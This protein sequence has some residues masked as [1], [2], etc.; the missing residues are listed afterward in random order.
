[1]L[2]RGGALL[3]LLAPLQIFSQ[4]NPYEDSE[5]ANPFFGNPF[6][7]EER[8]RREAE[9]TKQATGG[10]GGREVPRHFASRLY[11]EIF[12]TELPGVNFDEALDFRFSPKFSDLF[13]DDYIRWPVG[14]RYNFNTHLEGHFDLGLY[15]GNPFGSGD[16]AGAYSIEPGFKYT[17]RRIF[18]SD[19]NMAFGLRTRLPLADPPI[20]ISDGYA[21][22]QPY[23]SFSRRLRKDPAL[24]GYLNLRYEVVA[25]TPFTAH[26]EIPQPRDRISVS[27]GLIYYPGGRFRY[28]LEL[29]Y[30][31]NAWSLSETEKAPEGL[32]PPL[33]P[34]EIR[35]FRS[36]HELIAYPSI[37]WFPT[38][39]TRHGMW[40]PGNYDI[41]LRFEVPLVEKT[42]E[43]FAVSVRF[44]WYYNYRKFLQR[45]LPQM[46][47]RGG[48]DTRER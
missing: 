22:Y 10:E 34:V 46:F 31:T 42:G 32:S 39:E 28:G 26:P 30:R 15:T 43:D 27:P 38:R 47:R 8:R 4:V 6:E 40:I 14:V 37:T 41:G 45:D 7:P 20:E 2:A 24:L 3:A 44:R 48:D 12:D 35:A 25:D 16:G 5:E 18:G 21:R 33:T 23:L 19:W 36:V 9:E 11:H 17:L 13:G 29:E 1:M